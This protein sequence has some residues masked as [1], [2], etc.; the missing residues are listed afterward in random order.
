MFAQLETGAGLE[1]VRWIQSMRAAP[2][3]WLAMLLDFYDI[4]TRTALPGA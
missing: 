2:L 1:F 3:D 4:S